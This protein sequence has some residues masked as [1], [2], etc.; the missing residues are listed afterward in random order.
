MIPYRLMGGRAYPAAGENLRCTRVLGDQI[1]F[2]RTDGSRLS[3]D[4]A[5]AQ[6]VRVEHVRADDE[7]E[8]YAR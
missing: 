1:E 7:A 8:W 3:I 4:G 5:N 2:E 6:R